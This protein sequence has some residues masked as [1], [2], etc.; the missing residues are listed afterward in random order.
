MDSLYS[1]YAPR[2]LYANRYQF[3]SAWIYRE[4]NVPYALLRCIIKGSA[5]FTVEDEAYTVRG[6]DVFYIPQGSSFS[7]KAMED[8][9]FISVR[10]IGSVQLPETDLLKTLWHI[11]HHYPQVEDAAL[12]G[13][14]EGLH[15]AAQSEN[16]YRKLEIRGYLNLICAALARLSLGHAAA[17]AVQGQQKELEE[18]KRRAVASHVDDDPRIRLLV[19]YLTLH[20]EKNLSREDMCRISGVAESTLRR[21]F[22][23]QMGKTIHQFMKETR[24]IYA[25]R[26]LAFT[27]DAIGAIGWE[28]GY[29]SASYFGKTFREVFGTSPQAYRKKLSET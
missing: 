8:I 24:M 1:G 21:L 7:C 12:V 9:D 22:Y 18:M 4:S 29:E 14:F 25:A 23:R 11:R 3:S 28:L 27:Q 6:G 10:F 17:A 2:F 5:V 15:L 20:P 19:D 16:T 13:F 26:R